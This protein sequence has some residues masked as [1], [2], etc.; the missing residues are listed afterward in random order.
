MDVREFERL[1]KREVLRNKLENIVTAGTTV[2]DANLKQAFQ[3]QNVKVKFDYAVLKTS[4]LMKQVQVTDSELRAYYEKNKAGLVNSIPEQRK[5]RYV[6]IDATKVPVQITADDYQR[7]Y[8]ARKDQFAEPEQIDVRHILIAGGDDKKAAADAIKKQLDGGANF[9]EL[10]KKVSEDPGSKDKGGL[11]EGVLRNQFVKEFEQVAFSQPVGKISDPVKTN[12]GWHIIKTEAHRP[13]RA[14]T[15][16]EV[17]P[18]LEAEIKA[19]KGASAVEALANQIAS[20]ASSGDINAAAAKHGLKAIDTESFNRSTVLPGVGSSPQFMQQVFSAAPN[21]APQ[22]VVTEQGTVV[23]QVTAVQPPATPTFEQ[24]KAQ[25]ENRYRAERA[26]QMLAQKTQELADRSRA[27][28]DLRKAAKEAG[29]TMMT[30]ELVGPSAQVP[31]LGSM[32]DGPGAV[33]FSLNPGQMSGAL[34]AGQNGVVLKV[35]EKQEP[36]ASQFESQKDT[37]RAQLLEQKRAELMQLFQDQIRQRMMKDGVIRINDRE[38][39]M[40]FRSSGG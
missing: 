15:L 39:E 34:A 24:A 25:L 10:A 33:A 7:A 5:A 23:F 20:E 21:S 26:N 9:A 13:Q 1:V 4:D 29:A 32:S 19:Q 31:E 16:E 22:K 14:K 3:Q 28:N 35:T 27:L 6:V 17:K 18:Q 12:F 11:Y 30:S 37:L 8:D 40:L 38:Q 36:P 2:N